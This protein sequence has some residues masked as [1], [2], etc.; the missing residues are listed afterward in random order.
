MDILLSGAGAALIT[1]AIGEDISSNSGAITITA[2]ILNL[3]VGTI[4]SSGAL[5]LQPIARGRTIG[6]GDVAA[7]LFDLDVI[8]LALLQDGF[9]GITIGRD[10]SGAV[11]INAY[12]F[13]DPV[14]FW[15]VQWM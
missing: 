2:D 3:A 10:D 14:L 6:V 8:E 5:I 9:A 11:D 1:N 15:V 13:K 4:S 12:S 7:G